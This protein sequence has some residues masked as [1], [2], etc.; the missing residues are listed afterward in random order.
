[1]QWAKKV[2]NRCFEVVVHWRG[3]RPEPH[4]SLKKER[5]WEELS[6]GE[7]HA[8]LREWG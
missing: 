1:M 4:V 7:K 8:R 2:F 3:G 5:R 6:E